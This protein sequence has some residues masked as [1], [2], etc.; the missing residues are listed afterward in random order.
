MAGGLWDR[1]TYSKTL[2]QKKKTI[3]EII[4][5]NL[6]PQHDQRETCCTQFTQTFLKTR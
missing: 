1:E 4:E 6:S 3:I 2:S 5:E